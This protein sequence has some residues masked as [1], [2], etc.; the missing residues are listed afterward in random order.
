MRLKILQTYFLEIQGRIQNEIQEEVQQKNTW[1]NTIPSETPQNQ[2]YL[3]WISSHPP[4]SEQEIDRLLNEIEGLGPLEDLILDENIS[5]IFVNHR[6][7]IWFEKQGILY[8]HTDYFFSDL[9]FNR[10]LEKLLQESQRQLTLEE[11]SLDV[12]FRQFRLSVIG[13]P[14][15]PQSTQYCLRRHPENAWTLSKLKEQS[16]CSVREESILLKILKDKASIL[17]IGTTG[18]GKTSVINALLQALPENERCIIIE[19]TSELVLPNRASL[20]LLTYNLTNSHLSPQTQSDL[21]KKALRFK[22]DRLIMGE[23]RGAEAKDFLLTLSTGHDGCLATLHANDPQQALLR[24]EM[25]VQMGAPEWSLS[26]IRRLIFL[27]LNYILVV[28]KNS[29]GQ[30]TLKG[31][32]KISSLEDLGF[33]LEKLDPEIDSLKHQLI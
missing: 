27:S 23:I 17:V 15:T 20:K 11:P 3:N 31:I 6:D 13:H 22:P 30:R 16:W 18:S 25:L 33:L 21:L 10:I 19:D 8:P 26:T 32:Y 7:H 4:L 1:S 29:M 24:L 5:E 2:K 28:Q 9:S 14:L 12:S